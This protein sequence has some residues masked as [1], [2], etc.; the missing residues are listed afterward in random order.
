MDHLA[1]V[2]VTNPVIGTAI[3]LLPA[4][5]LMPT[6][7][8]LVLVSPVTIGPY[9]VIS[10]LT[11]ALMH[12]RLTSRRQSSIPFRSIAYIRS[13]PLTYTSLTRI[14]RPVGVTLFL[15][16]SSCTTPTQHLASLTSD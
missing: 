14:H 13:W 16:L 3:S 15:S 8:R 5:V 4:P 1:D 2:H 9:I 11:V 6:E 10:L 12:H 7:L